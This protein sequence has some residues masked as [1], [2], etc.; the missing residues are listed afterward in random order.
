MAEEIW[1]VKTGSCVLFGY[2]PMNRLFGGLVMS[3]YAHLQA[4]FVGPQGQ[5]RSHSGDLRI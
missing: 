5:G 2:L 3:S 1:G 4:T